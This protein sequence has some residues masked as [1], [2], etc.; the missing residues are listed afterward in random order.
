L[1]KLLDDDPKFH[2]YLKRAGAGTD[3][4]S[5]VEMLWVSYNDKV[6]EKELASECSKESSG[7]LQGNEW[8]K[9]PKLRDVYWFTIAVSD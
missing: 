8:G 3:D 6:G 9:H 5:G 7:D 4:Y 2:C 1:A